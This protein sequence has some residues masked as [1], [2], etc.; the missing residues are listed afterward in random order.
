M[1]SFAQSVLF[2]L[3]Y[4]SA[5]LGGFYGQLYFNNMALQCF[6]C[7]E[8][9]DTAESERARQ[10]LFVIPQPRWTTNRLMPRAKRSASR[11]KHN[12]TLRTTSRLSE[13]RSTVKTAPGK[14]INRSRRETNTAPI[15][16]H[17]WDATKVPRGGD[18]ERACKKVTCHEGEVRS[19][20]RVAQRACCPLHSALFLVVEIA[21]FCHVWEKK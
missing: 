18:R 2:T 9:A 3:A 5:H 13:E 10:S 17:P 11:S 8:I 14:G 15:R 19:Q 20:G 6:V 16:L 1:D 7:L 4:R 12:T 21:R